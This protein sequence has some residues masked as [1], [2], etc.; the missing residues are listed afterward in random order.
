MKVM[1]IAQ[2]VL[3]VAFLLALIL[4]LAFWGQPGL[5]AENPGLKG[6][7]MLLGI[8]VVLS[9][10]TIGLAQGR[11][12]GGSFG[13]A[14]GTFIV[15]LAVAI[16]GLWQETWKGGAGQGTI[17]LINTIHLLLG[18][19]AVGFGEMIVARVRRRAKAAAA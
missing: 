3:R 1:K 5:P 2:W 18:L 15:G 10:W 8:I 11:V 14:I 13:L 6:I 16:V 19:L 12:K 7:H 17:E 9:L 4:G